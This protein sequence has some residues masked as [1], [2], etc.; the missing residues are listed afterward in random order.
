MAFVAASALNGAK[1][2]LLSESAACRRRRLAA[3]LAP[4]NN[5]LGKPEKDAM[6]GFEFLVA[7]F[8]PQK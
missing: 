7:A 4:P 3:L 6:P 8:A 5:M 2:I 1:F